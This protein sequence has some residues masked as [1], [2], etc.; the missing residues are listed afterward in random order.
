MLQIVKSAIGIKS[1]DLFFTE[2]STS[3]GI[4]MY[5][6]VVFPGIGY[7]CDKPLL[8]YAKKLAKSLGFE[9]INVPYDGFDAKETIRN[10]PD[11]MQK[12]FSHA[13]SEAEKILRNVDWSQYSTILF[14]SKSIGTVVASKYAQDHGLHVH[15]IYYTPVEATFKYMKS[16]SGV[17][18]TGTKDQWVDYQS[19]VDGCRERNVF[20]HIIENANHSLE[21]G[22]VFQDLGILQKIMKMTLDYMQNALWE[23]RRNDEAVQK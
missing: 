7:H 8:Y 2:L 21:T 17:A 20:C 15:H 3:G 10:N 12:A 22:E 5:A 11:G 9:I 1:P 19:A 18:F 13:E 4:A 16:R 6:A 23:D 14:I